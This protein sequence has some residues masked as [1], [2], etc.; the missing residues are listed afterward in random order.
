MHRQE[1]SVPV[2]SKKVQLADFYPLIQGVLDNEGSFTLTITGTSMWP[3][4]LGERDRVTLVKAPPRLKK[5]DLPLYRRK[6]GQFVLHRIVRVNEDGSYDCCGDHQWQIERKLQHTQMIGVVAE[7]ERKGKKFSADK[8]G[9]RCWVR[10]W[11]GM[12]RRR[13]WIFRMHGHWLGLKQ[14]VRRL[15]CRK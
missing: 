10:F 6:N 7:L 15:F 12:L 11:C 2:L 5:Y 8:F 4:I 14:R 13:E 3:T 1:F 9:Y